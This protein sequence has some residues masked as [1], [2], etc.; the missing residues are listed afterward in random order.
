M[1]YS[2]KSLERKE[3]M[4]ELKRKISEDWKSELNSIGLKNIGILE[5]WIHLNRRAGQWK[6]KYE[7]LYNWISS[8]REQWG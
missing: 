5:H 3:W 8:W 4:A 2:G 1:N 6:I 7:E